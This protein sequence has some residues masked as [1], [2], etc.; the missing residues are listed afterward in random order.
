MK[1]KFFDIHSHIN[2]KKFDGDIVDVIKRMKDESVWSIIVG[3]D[4][5]SS[6]LAAQISYFYEGVFS[7]IGIHPTDNTGES[8][9]ESY[10][11]ELIESPKVVAV[12]ECGLDYFRAKDESAEEKKRQKDLFEV[13]LEFA[14]KIGKPLMIH[15]RDAHTDMLDL[16]SS[17]KK[18]YGDKLRG[19]IHFFSEG[20]DTAKKYFD[21]DFTISFTGVL[22]FT[23]DYD[24]VVKYAPLEMIMSETDSPYVSPAPYRGQRNEPIYVKEVVKRIAD[25]RGEDYGVV[26]KAMVENAMRVFGIVK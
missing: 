5:R 3:T 14:I 16:L 13:Q 8:F 25:I 11:D 18:E 9:N 19:D 21:L 7:A 15:C 12:G 10:F 26:E 23:G 4:R 6:Q 20:V 1:P 24:E 22:T 17:K 2:D